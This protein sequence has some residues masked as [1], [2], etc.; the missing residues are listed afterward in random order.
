MKNARSAILLVLA[1]PFFCHAQFMDDFESGEITGWTTLTGDGQA[2]MKLI[3]QDGFVRLEVDGTKDRHNVWWAITKRDVSGFLDMHKLEDPAFELRVEVR[4]RASHAP[5]RANIMINTQRTTNFHK[6]LREYDLSDTEWHT[7]SMTTQD[8]DAVN[9]DELN[10]QIGITDWGLGVYHLDIDYYKADIVKVDTNAAD[11]G[12]P[13]VYHPPIPNV[14]TFSHHLSVTHDALINADFPKV[15]FHK[16]TEAE[17]RVLTISAQQWAILR[18]DLDQNENARADGAAILELTTHSIAQ[19]GD[20]ISAYG[21]DLGIEFDK[22]RI[23][24]ILGGDPHWDQS[25]VTFQTFA[26]GEAL[27]KL[28]NGQMIFD[29]ELAKERGG[30]TY[31]TIPRP[32]MQRLLDGTTKGL[33]IRPLGAL[34]ASIY[35]SEEAGQRFAPTLYFNTR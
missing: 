31:A 12:E 32:V 3:P 30:K 20:Y 11:L 24:E 28:V 9:G 26:Q 7:I 33:T 13:L 15:N 23:V 25:S 8:L 16:W 22:I 1:S 19:G 17:E 27:E 4:V 5:R 34:D 2:T 10:V 21:E 18:W 14:D 29:T 35:D 6:Q